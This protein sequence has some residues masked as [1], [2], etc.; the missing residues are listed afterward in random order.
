MPETVLNK[1]SSLSTIPDQRDMEQDARVASDVK[2]YALVE[3]DGRNGTDTYEVENPEDILD[4]SISSLF[5]IAPIA[6]STPH[7]DSLHTYQPPSDSNI[8]V[9]RLSLPNPSSENWTKLQANHLWL[10]A[11]YLSDRIARRA[12]ATGT[13]INNARVA[14]LGAAAGLPGVVACLTGAQVVSTDWDDDGIL[15]VLRGNF[16]RNGCKE[17]RYAVKGFRWGANSHSLLESL[18]TRSTG[19][20]ER[21]D[22]LL[23]ADTIWVTEAHGQLLDSIWALLKQDGQGVAHIVAGLHTGRGPLERFVQ[24]AK[25]RGGNVTFQ[26]EV[27]WRS[28]GGWEENV[29]GLSGSGLE[30]ERGV[31][32]YFTL[33]I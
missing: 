28:E 18:S 9:V 13:V 6:F 23:L 3:A 20:S 10:S 22:V 2:R 29:S 25:A 19:D 33:T 21:F 31:V 30:E 17:D 4:E 16:E 14:E 8:P 24:A 15:S 12:L 11:I 32:V 26:T 7:P 5:S 1:T 27:K